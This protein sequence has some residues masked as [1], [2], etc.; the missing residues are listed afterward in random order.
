M[1]SLAFSAAKAAAGP[2]RVSILDAKGNTLVLFHASMDE[3]YE[4][5]VNATRFP[6]EGGA[7]ISD[8][9][10]A[11]PFKF[12]FK[13]IISDT[14][15]GTSGALVTQAAAT[16]ATSLLPPLGVAAAGA[17]YALYQAD[18]EDSRPTRAT[19]EK[20]VRLQLGIPDPDPKA[21]KPAGR[22]LTV[23]S[24]MGMWRNMFIQNLGAP[25]GPDSNGM[26]L[27]NITFEQLR[28]VK[29]QTVDVAKFRNAG[30]AADVADIGD[31]SPLTDRSTE[32]YMAGRKFANAPVGRN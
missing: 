9:L 23:R 4:T 20:L 1:S 2:D 11:E 22:L 3:N 17:A 14:P 19:Y 18:Q 13:G 24:R 27:F 7:L 6:V 29:P 26:I 31:Q 21:P 15:L 8:H 16:A 25:R 10:N 5:T 32:G 28:I 30:L 12:T